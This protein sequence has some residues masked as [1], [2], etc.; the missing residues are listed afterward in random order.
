MLSPTLSNP[1]ELSGYG[2]LQRRTEERCAAY[3]VFSC[4]GAEELIAWCGANMRRVRKLYRRHTIS[5]SRGT[6]KTESAT[7]SGFDISTI[8]KQFLERRL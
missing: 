2:L 8:F 5:S 1:N 7:G 4:A 3:S 6:L